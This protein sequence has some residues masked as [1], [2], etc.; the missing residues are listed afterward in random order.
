MCG[1]HNVH[2][3][4]GEWASR[5]LQDG[6]ITQVDVGHTTQPLFLAVPSLPPGL[7]TVQVQTLV[8][9]WMTQDV[10]HAFTAA[11]LVLMLQL[12]RFRAADG[13]IIKLHTSIEVDDTIQVPIFTGDECANPAC[14]LPLYCN[15]MSSRRSPQNWSS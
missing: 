12:G 7:S 10:A 13:R 11:P 6:E 3:V 15:D 1:R 14:R 4:Q 2:P 9:S 8:S 5:K